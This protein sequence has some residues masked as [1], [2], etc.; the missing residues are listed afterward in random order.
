MDS[1]RATVYVVD[2]DM[3]VRKGL[4][5]LIK[6]VGMNVHTCEDAQGFL[7]LYDPDK[8]SCVVLDVRMP[9]ISGLELQE[10]LVSQKINVPV[11]FISGHGDVPMAMRA[12]KMGAVDFIEKPFREQALLESIQ[13]AIAMDV[14]RRRKIQDVAETKKRIKS[15]TAREREV[16]NG[17]IEGKPNKTIAYDLDLNKKTVEYHRSNVMKKMGVDSVAGLVLLIFK[18]NE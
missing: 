9:G 6:S 16:M 2:D 17:I 18:A 15:L 10:K 1:S 13:N 4:S 8:P 3:A 14:N 5:L 7:G 12:V 11:I